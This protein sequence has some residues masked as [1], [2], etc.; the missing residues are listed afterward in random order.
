MCFLKELFLKYIR[1]N[2]KVKEKFIN[3]KIMASSLKILSDKRFE[4]FG[5]R[6]K[7]VSRKINTLHRPK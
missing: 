3:S 1:I 6:F 2:L 7:V 5:K 4:I